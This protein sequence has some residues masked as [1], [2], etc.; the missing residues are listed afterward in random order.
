MHEEGL[1]P[2]Q[3]GTRH[4]GTW[5]P[6]LPAATG[7]QETPHTP[8][9]LWPG[10]GTPIALPPGRSCWC[11]PSC[12]L[13]SPG[14]SV[15]HLCLLDS[16]ADQTRWI[17]RLTC[18]R[19]PGCPRQSCRDPGLPWGLGPRPE[20]HSP[21]LPLYSFKKTKVPFLITENL[22]K[23][24]VERGKP[25]VRNPRPQVPSELIFSPV[26]VWPESVRLG[27]SP[28]GAALLPQDDTS[29]SALCSRHWGSCR[30]QLWHQCL[31][32]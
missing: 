7:M 15:I 31:L 21:L 20:R 29:N 19:Q 10:V 27:C 3:V 2:S 1:L 8:D 5:I 4:R 22:E 30:E 23:S 24:Q 32:L 12:P 11:G 28:G 17:S 14:T 6:A 13:E 18:P 26:C 25:P 9:G 16:S